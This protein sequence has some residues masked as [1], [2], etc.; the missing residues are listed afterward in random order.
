[1]Y[2]TPNEL[3][4]KYFTEDELKI[5]KSDPIYFHL[6]KGPLR[7]VNLLKNKTLL[8]TLDAEEAESENKRRL[9][10]KNLGLS[11]HETSNSSDLLDEQNDYTSNNKENFDSVEVLEVNPN[12]DKKIPER[13]NTCTS[14]LDS[15]IS[16][17]RKEGENNNN[18]NND[19]NKITHKHFLK[20]NRKPVENTLLN[21]IGVG[22][23]ENLKKDFLNRNHSSKNFKYKSISNS[24]NP[25]PINLQ[26]NKVDSYNNTN[27]KLKRNIKNKLDNPKTFYEK[28]E[29]EKDDRQIPFINKEKEIKKLFLKKLT[30]NLNS[31]KNAKDSKNFEKKLTFNDNPQDSKNLLKDFKYEDIYYAIRRV[32]K[33]NKVKSEE[34]A[35]WTDN[36]IN[37]IKENYL[38]PN[39]KH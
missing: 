36:Y 22:L 17:V 33:L 34:E 24:S 31:F 37:K 10:A 3:L 28:N 39:K 8:E 2:V 26:F 12:F 20:N 30:S 6:N 9:L 38:S 15:E 21:K 29:K 5:I 16:E 35:R 27:R 13:M 18:N 32:S 4:L 25:N 23:N 11:D 1:M 7:D 19:R 14:S